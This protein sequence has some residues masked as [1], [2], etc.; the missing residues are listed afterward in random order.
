MSRPDATSV[1]RLQVRFCE[2]DLMGVVHHGNYFTY[3]EA[4]RVD[5]LHKRGVSYDSWVR[6]GIHLPVV[7]AKARYKAA[8]KFDQI[9]DVETTMDS[10]SRVTV[11]FRYTIRHERTLICEAETLLACVGDELKLKRIPPDVADVFKSGELPAEQHAP[12]I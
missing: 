8:A 9:L 3:C 12:S 7:E 1:H 10:L 4:A 2:T 5:W 6:H 11:R